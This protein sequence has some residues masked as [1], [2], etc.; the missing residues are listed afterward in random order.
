MVG[1]FVDLGLP[2]GGF[3]DVLTLPMDPDDWPSVGT[4]L[5]FEVLQHHPGQ[6]RLYPLDP[7]YRRA[8][9]GWGYTP[10]QWSDLKRRYPVGSVV[11]LRVSEV[12]R[13]NRECRITDGF[14]IEGV[15]WSGSEPGIGDEADYL[16]T[17][18]RDTVRRLLLRRLTAPG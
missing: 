1:I 17:E 10:E 4:I 2:A 8:E 3:V 13:S 5:D 15:D 7:R 18:H 14:L 6:V 9:R 11:T 16:V 12:F